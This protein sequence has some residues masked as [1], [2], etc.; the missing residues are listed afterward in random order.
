MF[1]E[2]LESSLKRIM[3]ANLLLFKNKS[4]KSSCRKLG[5]AEDRATGGTAPRTV[6]AI[7]PGSAVS[8]AQ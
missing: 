3:T 1:N 4:I 7:V 2:S 6:K 8:T 5:A